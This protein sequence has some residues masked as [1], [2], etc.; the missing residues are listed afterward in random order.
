LAFATQS[1]ARLQPHFLVLHEGDGADAVPFHFEEPIVAF[2]RSLHQGRFHGLDGD[3]HFRLADAF[4][5]A[6]VELLFFLAG[7][8]GAGAS[9][10]PVLRV[11]GRLLAQTRS[12]APA[13]SRL[14]WRA[15][16]LRAISSCVL[17][18]STL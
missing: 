1:A 18:E 8:A 3:R 7:A 10:P 9:V 5:A 6:E 16:R 13:V 17:P 2:R 14:V 12:A 11:A 15:G 4:Q